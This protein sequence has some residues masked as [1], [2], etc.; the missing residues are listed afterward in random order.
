MRTSAQAPAR[1]DDD[2]AEEGGRA[3]GL[4]PLE[5]ELEGSLEADDE[6]EAAQEQDL[7]K[8]KPV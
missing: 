1:S 8:I 4:L 7:K 2:A 6:C 3:L 5:E